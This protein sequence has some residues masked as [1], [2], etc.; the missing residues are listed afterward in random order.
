M[1]LTIKLLGIF[2]GIIIFNFRSEGSE[3]CIGI[4]MTCVFILI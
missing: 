3:E 1:D 2:Y 4:T